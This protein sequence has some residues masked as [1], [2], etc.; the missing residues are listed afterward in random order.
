MADKFPITRGQGGD[1]QG[2]GHDS[3]YLYY[4]M[5]LAAKD[6]CKHIAAVMVDF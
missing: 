5:F 2:I 3:T 4:S 1:A 6:Y